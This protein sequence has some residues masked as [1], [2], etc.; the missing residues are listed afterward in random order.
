MLMTSWNNPAYYFLTYVLPPSWHGGVTEGRGLGPSGSPLYARYQK[1]TFLCIV[2][3]Q[4]GSVQHVDYQLWIKLHHWGGIWV[5]DLWLGRKKSGNSGKNSAGVKHPHSHFYS[6]PWFRH[7]VTGLLLPASI[8]KVQIVSLTGSGLG[9]VGRTQTSSIC[10]E[11]TTGA[12]T[13]EVIC[14]YVVKSRKSEQ[15]GL[16]ANCAQSSWS[17]VTWVA[18]P[19]LCFS[20]LS[21]FCTVVLMPS[22]SWFS[23]VM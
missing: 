15:T 23:A 4:L 11:A 3:A 16:S 6:F 12:S 10:S 22:L 13:A 21:S 8:Y 7:W 18:F 19:P 17:Q 5:S 9:E 1:T 20:G 2:G 14:K